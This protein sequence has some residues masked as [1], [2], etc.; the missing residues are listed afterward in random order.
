MKK[1]IV[2]TEVEQKHLLNILSVFRELVMQ[3]KVL[4][5]CVCLSLTE[6]DYLIKKVKEG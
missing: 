6:L 3:E 1:V 4:I 2:L 5:S